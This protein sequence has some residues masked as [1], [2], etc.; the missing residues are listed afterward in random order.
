MAYVPPHKRAS[1]DHNERRPTPAMLD[2]QKRRHLNVGSFR[3]NADKSGKIVYSNSA[4]SKWFAVGLR[5]DDQIPASDLLKPVQV[6]SVERVADEKP[7]A[8]VK[9]SGG[10]G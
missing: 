4:I 10:I 8:L 1:K 5:G 6:D 9:S 3:T 7:L 2:P